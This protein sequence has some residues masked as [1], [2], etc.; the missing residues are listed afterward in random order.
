MYFFLKFIA[1]T[2]EIMKKLL[3]FSETNIFLKLYSDIIEN[4][5]FIKNISKIKD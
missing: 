2:V 3:Y 4:I 1:I 5:Q